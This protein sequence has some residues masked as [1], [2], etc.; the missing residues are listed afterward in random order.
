MGSEACFERIALN[1]S[2][3]RMDQS[4]ESGEEIAG[5]LESGGIEGSIAGGIAAPA[6]ARGELA[7][8]LGKF[9]VARKQRLDVGE[10]IVNGMR[11]VVMNCH[12]ICPV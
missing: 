7:E 2:C 10:A 11:A 4:T 12:G 1:P 8:L 5:R 3:G 6:V 9:R